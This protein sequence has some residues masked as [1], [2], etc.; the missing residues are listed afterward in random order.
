[1]R[2]TAT[3]AINDT[4]KALPPAERTAA[5]VLINK[6]AQAPHA[7]RAKVIAAMRG[8]GVKRIGDV[9]LSQAAIDFV[10]QTIERMD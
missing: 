2:Y 7:A 4:F 8:D 3:N 10:I 1:M 5:Q 9:V 6:A